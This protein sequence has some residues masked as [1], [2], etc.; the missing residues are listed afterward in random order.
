MNAQ[1]FSKAPLS[2]DRLTLYLIT[3]NIIPECASC[4]TCFHVN[5]FD[6]SGTYGNIPIPCHLPA[7][8]N[9]Q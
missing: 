3:H 5:K 7:D 9:K 2:P 1:C 6:K 8:S 4:V